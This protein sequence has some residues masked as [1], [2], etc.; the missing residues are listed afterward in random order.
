MND[1]DGIQNYNNLKYGTYEMIN[2]FSFI[3]F[4]GDEKIGEKKLQYGL[5]SS[6]TRWYTLKDFCP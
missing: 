3:I 4:D 2:T 5:G 6:R 1:Y